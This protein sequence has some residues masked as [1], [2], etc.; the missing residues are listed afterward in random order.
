M[1][2]FL[3]NQAY[4][5]AQQNRRKAYKHHHRTSRKP[6]AQID[7]D[8]VK[9]T[10]FQILYKLVDVKFL[11]SLLL[12]GYPDD[13]SVVWI[14]SRK[15]KKGLFGNDSTQHVVQ[16]IVSIINYRILLLRLVI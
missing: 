3:F 10:H 12:Q 6:L 2:N 16:K 1:I 13:R 15:N 14:E 8:L 4:R 7:K 5:D 9:I 11:I